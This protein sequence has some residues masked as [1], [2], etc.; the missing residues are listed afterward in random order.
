MTRSRFAP[1]LVGLTLILGSCGGGGSDGGVIGVASFA[2]TYWLALYEPSG[3]AGGGTATWGTAV[4][5]GAG[6]VTLD[7]MAND[8]G[9]VSAPGAQGLTYTVDPDGTLRVFQAA[10][11]VVRGGISGD[12]NCAI[13]ATTSTTIT[14]LILVLIRSVGAFSPATLTG[15]FHMT[16]YL[17]QG[18]AGSLHSTK[19]AFDGVSAYDGTGAINEDGLQ[20]GGMLPGTYTVA[21]SGLATVSLFGALHDGCL[22]TGGG[23]G[24]FAGGN[25][26]STPPAILLLMRAATAATNATL[27]GS[28]WVVGIEKDLTGPFESITGTITADGVNQLSIDATRFDGTTLGAVMGSA[29]YNVSTDG[30]VVAD[31]SGVFGNEDM[32]GAVSADGRIAIISGGSVSG[33]NPVLFVLCRK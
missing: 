13:L 23:F 15:D 19:V 9:M 12:G 1:L 27:S 26:N 4:S 8:G 28:Y 7:G 22:M 14:P 29:V 32:V 16:A 10:T 31:R 30:A 18:S 2:G 33:S 21:P 5:D 6:N 20:D 24:A 3:G 11:E 25:A 17:D